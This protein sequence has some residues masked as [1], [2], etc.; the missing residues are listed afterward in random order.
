MKYTIPD[1]NDIEFKECKLFVYIK[2]FDVKYHYVKNDDVQSQN[3][4][5]EPVL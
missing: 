5:L 2:Y 3:E 1:P 4:T